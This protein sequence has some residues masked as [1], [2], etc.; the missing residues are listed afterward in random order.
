MDTPASRYEACVSDEQSHE[1]GPFEPKTY[2]LPCWLSA[3][4]S[5]LPA[6]PA[7]AFTVTLGPVAARV[8]FCGADNDW[9]L[10]RAAP[11]CWSMAALRTVTSATSFSA[12]AAAAVASERAF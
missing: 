2:G 4:C 1:P 12:A 11:T 5:A 9:Y 3:N 8:C 10:A 7:G 6:A